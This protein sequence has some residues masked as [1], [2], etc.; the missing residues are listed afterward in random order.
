MRRFRA[1]TGSIRVRLSLAPVISFECVL[2]R[3]GTWVPLLDGRDLAE[4]NNVLA[5]LLPIFDYIPGDK[6]PPPAPKHTNAA[7]R[8]RAPRI[9]AANRRPV[10]AAPMPP[11][12]ET[13]SFVAVNQPVAQSFSQEQYAVP[14]GYQPYD[15]ESVAQESIAESS[16]AEDDFIQSQ[17]LG[18]RKRTQDASALTMSEQEHIMYGDALLDYFMT[19]GD[20]PAATKAAAPVPPRNFQVNRAID[21]QG[22]TALHWACA[23]GDLDIIRDLINR[24]AEIHCLS[25]KDETPLIRAVLFTNNFERNTMPE[26][27]ELLKETISFRDWF[28]A[29][30]FNH[31]A[32]ATR[33]KGKWK[34]SRYYGQVLIEKLREMVS[35]R[36]V[37]H[38]L[39]SQDSNGDTAALTAAKHGCLKL[40]TLL[41]SYCPECGDIP[42]KQG[43]TANEILMMIS[44]HIHKLDSVDDQDDE[45]DRHFMEHSSQTAS[46]SNSRHYA[47][48]A[49]QH[50][51]AL[52]QR[53]GGIMDEVGSR[54]FRA[55]GQAPRRR[56]TVDGH[57][58][59]ADD[60]EPN[61][62]ANQNDKPTFDDLRV[63]SNDDPQA[64]I[65]KIDQER[66]TLK[67]H[68][69]HLTKHDAR[70]EPF[71]DVTSKWT[72]VRSHHEDVMERLQRVELHRRCKR[73]KVLQP[74]LFPA[75]R[76][77]DGKFVVDTMASQ[78]D[79]M[80]TGFMLKRM[81]AARRG[82]VTELIHQRSD[83]GAPAHMD[84]HRKLVCL[85]TGMKEDEVDP[86]APGIADALEFEKRLR[87]IE[88]SRQN[89]GAV[90][91]EICMGMDVVGVP[92]GSTN[93]NTSVSANV[94]ATV[95]ADGKANG[96]T[97]GV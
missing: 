63:R 97:D 33:S 49:A 2:M 47:T 13:S 4:K 11:P 75:A 81:F 96:A 22:N 42:N 52:A 19:V 76:V 77:E 67:E 28:G 87:S 70:F 45:V 61:A 85:A 68:A 29:T 80:R 27:A 84:S 90:N 26:L 56:Y 20:G 83:T 93:A 71:S 21:N 58:S 64:M 82:L 5:R 53:V 40:A 12:E 59:D 65:K 46:P 3:E 94:N 23:M 31:L 10:A 78:L 37:N 38:T 39:C 9:A 55:Y 1:A 35:P 51:G 44:H 57:S 91:T 41:I 6:S 48:Y 66:A 92:N 24:G 95:N 18:K 16:A 86:M 15:E 30:V 74:K 8:P 54:L 17:N 50:A 34:S 89:N 79:L 7:S 36:E 88:A 25:S 62:E 43:E 32:Q 72:K 69:D 14:H 60:E 73:L